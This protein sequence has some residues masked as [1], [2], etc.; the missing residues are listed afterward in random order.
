M[1]EDTTTVGPHR[2]RRGVLA[3]VVATTTAT[4]GCLDRVFDPP[5]T[6]LTGLRL[7]NWT[8]RAATVRLTLRRGDETVYTDRLSLAP[9]REPGSVVSVLGD[10]SGEPARY[11]LRAETAAGDAALERRLPP[12]DDDPNWEGCAFAD[13]DL[14]PVRRDRPAA[15]RTFEAHLQP[16]TDADDFSADRCPR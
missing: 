13:V 6:R 12:A 1:T 11:H 4:T 15:G 10:W 2:S 7:H 9:L 8:T 14:E 5:R 3:T 16:V